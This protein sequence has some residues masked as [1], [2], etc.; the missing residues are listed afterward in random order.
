LLSDLVPLEKVAL[1]HT[2]A[3]DRVDELRQKAQHLLPEGELLSLDITPVFG[4][5]LGPGALGFA[6]VTAQ[7]E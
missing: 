6:C 3:L 1:V 2:H 7:R 4:T 5:H